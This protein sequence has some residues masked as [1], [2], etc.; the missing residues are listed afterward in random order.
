MPFIMKQINLSDEN[1]IKI[2]NAFKRVNRVDF[3][4]DSIID[5]NMCKVFID[6]EQS[7]QAYMIQN[8][9]FRI[10]AG[11]PILPFI[12]SVAKTLDNFAIILP[13]DRGWFDLISKSQFLKTEVINRFTMNSTSLDIGYL[14]SI[15]FPNSVSIRQ[16]TTE[17]AK[18]LSAHQEFSYHLQNFSNYDDFMKRGVGYIALCDEVIVGVASSALVCNKGI[19][20]NIM[21]SP[22]VRHNGIALTL[23]AQLIANT[24]DRGIEANWDAGN[25]ASKHLAEK[26]GYTTSSNYHALKITPAFA[27]G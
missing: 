8:G 19:E 25:N 2:V 23:G 5:S 17:D 14:R 16:I 27:T 13:S 3:S 15:P 18:N 6:N 11:R 7:P 26:L 9:I 20:V 10:F 12:K 24:I 4:I 1:K 22:P 21:V